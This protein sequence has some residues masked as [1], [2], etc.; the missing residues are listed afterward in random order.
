M[1]GELDIEERRSE[2]IATWGK[3]Y[4]CQIALSVIP[5]P[6]YSF[7]SGGRIHSTLWA[8]TKICRLHWPVIA[9]LEASR[10]RIH[11]IQASG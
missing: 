10:Y 5:L 2:Y 9:A 7:D 6:L 3:V 8:E 1:G 11:E 4:L